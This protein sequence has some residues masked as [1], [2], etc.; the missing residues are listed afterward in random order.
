MR[1]PTPQPKPPSPA[2]R[3]HRL[4]LLVEHLARTGRLITSSSIANVMPD[5]KGWITD[6]EIKWVRDEV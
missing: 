2:N 5:T 6:E 1:R 4:S 3:K